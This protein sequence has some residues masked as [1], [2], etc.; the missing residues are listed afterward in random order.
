MAYKHILQAVRAQRPLVHCISNIVTANDCAN[1]VLAVGGSPI[2]AQA[3]PEMEQISAKAGAVVLNTGAPDE[4][5]FAACRIAGKTANAAGIPVVLDPVGAGATPWRLAQIQVLLE[6]VKPA[7]V[8]VNAGEAKALLG[9][10]QTEHGVDSPDAEANAMQLAV[11]LAEKLDCTVLLSGEEDCVAAGER[12]ERIAG[13]STWMQRL[14]GAGCML[15]ALCGA[16]AAV[17]LDAFAAA[18]AA[19]QFWKMCA[20]QAA[21]QSAGLGQFHVALLDCASQSAE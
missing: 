21:A 19:A 5:K 3:V 10:G 13:G 2:M 12:C 1:L 18:A 14:T 9:M 4:A 17:E 15:S 16:F 20:A 8:H 7:I 6:Q 11:R